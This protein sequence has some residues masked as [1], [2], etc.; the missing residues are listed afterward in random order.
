MN[1]LDGSL[2][3]CGIVGSLRRGSY[4]HA[5]LRAAGE[6]APEGMDLRVFDRLAEIPLFDEDV[7]AEGDPEPV[8][9][10]K[11]A[12]AE[13]DALLVAT[14]E[15]NY[16]VPGVLKNAIDWASRPPGKIRSGGEARGDPG[17][18]ARPHGDRPRAAAAETDVCLHRHSH[19]AAARGPGVPRPREVRRRGPAHGRGHP[20]V[21]GHADAGA[22]GLD[23]PRAPRRYGAELTI[24]DKEPDMTFRPMQISLAAA[25][26]LALVLLA[27]PGA[28]QTGAAAREPAMSTQVRSTVP[29]SAR[30]GAA[31]GDEAIHPFRFR[32]SD[33]DLADLRRRIAATRWPTRETVPDATQ[34]VQL[35]TMQKL[36]RYWA[37]EY[38]WR[39]FEARLNALPQFTTNIDGLDIHYIHV[40]SRHPGAL[41]IVITHGWPGSVVEM[42]KVIEPLTDPTAHGGTAADAFDVVI[43]SLPGYGFSGKPTAGGWEPVRIAGAWIALM[44]R[45][46]YTR[47]AA[48][49]GD[50]G[51]PVTEQIAVQV[52]S[53]VVGIH[54]N[55]P[56]TVPPEIA[57][58]LQAGGPPPPG[59]SADEKHAYE[60]LDFFYKKGL[61]YA[62]EMS[63]RPQTL[64][65]IEDSPIGLAAWILDHDARSYELIARVFDGGPRG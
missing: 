55:M 42:M 46:G 63:N 11:R 53:Q 30:E 15:Y 20:P 2:V 25:G 56:S 45:L 51:D 65:G 57:R 43:P 35:A 29:A 26:V 61:A 8:Q 60:Q 1:T 4:N 47:F 52:P 50:W 39:R 27:S 21:R 6:L 3:V 10:L 12:I 64:Y 14:P 44:N 22:G 16:G 13:A 24:L 18:D 62:Q 7:E 41:P 49:G 36:A 38:D 34:G 23:A 17:R 58:A 19:A 59:L 5:L 33:A 37:T 40:R 48:Q 28:A 54:L 32:A 9:A 31:P